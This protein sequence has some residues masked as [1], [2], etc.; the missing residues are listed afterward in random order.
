MRSFFKIRISR[1]LVLCLIDLLCGEYVVVVGAVGAAVSTTPGT[2]TAWHAA[3]TTSPAAGE[4]LTNRMNLCLCPCSMMVHVLKNRIAREKT[5]R[6]A[7]KHE[8]IL[9]ASMWSNPAELLSSTL[10]LLVHHLLDLPILA[11]AEAGV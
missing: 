8:T 2:G 3:A 11:A 5:E 10:L 1:Q 6:A 4:L 9:A 7:A